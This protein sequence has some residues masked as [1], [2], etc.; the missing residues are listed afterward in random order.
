MNTLDFSETHANT[1]FV[2]IS[3]LIYKIGVR[4]FASD[5][6]SGIT[7]V[8]AQV[9]DE[10]SCRYLARRPCNLLEKVT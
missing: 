9:N 5:V 7:C 1:Y 8:K 4:T 3:S 6:F 2:V 10:L